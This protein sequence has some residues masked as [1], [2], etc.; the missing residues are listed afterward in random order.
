MKQYL[1]N[2]IVIFFVLFS[3]YYTDKVIEISKYNDTILVSINEYAS[4]KD[5]ECREGSINEYGIVLGFSG[6]K[7]DK[8]KSYSNMKGIGFKEELIEYKENKCI[9]NKE[10]NVDKY[11]IKG[12]DYNKNISLV[13]NITNTKYYKNMINVS[14]NKDVELNLLFNYN[15]LSNEIDNITNHSNILFKGKTNEELNNFIKI[16]HNEIYCV[17]IDDFDIK[18][19]CS[20]KKLNSINKVLEIQDNLLNN[21]KNSIKNGTIFFISENNKNLKELSTTINYIQ[22]RGYKI[23]TINELLK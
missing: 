14:N 18:K 22:S 16:L 21:V 11:I 20:R 6:L 15:D 10:D 23:V 17:K 1:K 19:I 2:I 5:Y 4:S 12:N 3:F 9:L 13:I 7:V 8:N